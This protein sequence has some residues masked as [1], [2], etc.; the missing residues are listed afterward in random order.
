MNKTSAYE[1]FFVPFFIIENDMEEVD[2]KGKFAK[3]LWLNKD[4]EQVSRKY[5]ESGKFYWR[6]WKLG[7]TMEAINW[8]RNYR[9]KFLTHAYM[10]SEAPIDPVEAFRNSG[11]LI[12]DPYTI[13]QFEENCKSDSYKYAELTMPDEKSHHAIQQANLVFRERQT[14]LKIWKAP[15]NHILKVRNRYV[16]AVDIGGATVH[17]DFSVMTVIDR[18]GMVPG[19][20][21]K[22]EVVARW[23]GHLRHDK[24]AW[25]A[26]ALAHVYS[27]ALLVI[28]S[29]TA[30]RERDTNT[31]GDHFGTIVEEISHFYPN[32]YQRNSS[33]EKV[34]DRLE[35]RYGFQTNKLTKQWVIDLLTAFVDDQL[36]DEPDEDMFKE[37][38]IYERKEDGSMGNI[39]GRGNHDDVLMST[40]IGLWVST[41][42]MRAPSWIQQDKRQR[43]S[44]AP[45]TEAT[46]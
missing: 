39:K 33:P 31:E 42:D 44:S 27:D 10:A 29:N 26:A 9:R 8:Y 32:L 22:P 2:D 23:R 7:A 35:M 30:D 11:N 43:R 14:E 28:E 38:R 19:V 25:K 18:F 20:N 13:D 6:M 41:N 4:S 5:K 40:A 17:S 1:F 36:Y 12:F 24:L 34:Q 16:I 37:L 3:W 15:N 45:M 21:G 46:I